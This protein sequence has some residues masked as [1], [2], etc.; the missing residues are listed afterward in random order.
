MI[1]CSG[2]SSII[3]R[4]VRRTTAIGFSKIANEMNVFTD[5]QVR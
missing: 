4:K 2:A 5:D 1:D 3:S